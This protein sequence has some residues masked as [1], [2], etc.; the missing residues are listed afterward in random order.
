[1]SR[2]N[3][4]GHHPPPADRTSQAPKRPRKA[5]EAK[6]KPAPRE[7]LADQ[8]RKLLG[9]HYANKYRTGRGS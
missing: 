8:T 9:K 7:R 3:R 4:I 1:M 5:G 2:G 6:G